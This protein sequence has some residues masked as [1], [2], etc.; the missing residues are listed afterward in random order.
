ME[1]NK[2]LN[3]KEE[4]MG[5]TKQR[6]GTLAENLERTLS[7]HWELHAV[8]SK[9]AAVKDPNNTTRDKKSKVKKLK[10]A[11]REAMG[12]LKKAQE[13]ARNLIKN[14]GKSKTWTA[15]D[16]LEEVLDDTAKPTPEDIAG[17]LKAVLERTRPKETVQELSDDDDDDDD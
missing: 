8:N 3:E 11:V 5:K 9:L 10:T 13:S 15:Y 14:R 6:E 2:I 1:A 16:I 4:N 17:M 7:K 12:E